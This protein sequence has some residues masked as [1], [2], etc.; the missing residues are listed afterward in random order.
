MGCLTR[1]LFP[2]VLGSPA[3]VALAAQTLHSRPAPEPAPPPSVNESHNRTP[4]PVLSA[5]TSLQVETLRH[6]PMKAGETIEGRLVY[7]LYVDGKL[8]VPKDTPVHGTVTSLI[9]DSKER[10]QG[11]LRGDFTPFHDAKV[12]FDGLTLASGPL[13]LTTS[14]ASTGAMVLHLAS[15][16]VRPKQSFIARR[17]AD[18][19]TR[20]HDQV[21]FFTAPGLGD[22]AKQM[23]YHQLPYHPE[24]IPAHTSWMFELAAPLTLPARTETPDPAPVSVPSNPGKLETRYGRLWSSQSWTKITYW[25]FRKALCWW[26]G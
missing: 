23:L 25:W 7:P 24:R 19:K 17:W 4:Q 21:A 14:G 5:G 12:K 1:W 3:F 6:Y 18:A 16:G 22:R 10:W 26:D 13:Q 8:V 9:P 11:R 2:A 15:S 20:M